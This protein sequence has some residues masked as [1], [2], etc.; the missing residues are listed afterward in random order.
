MTKLFKG[1][2][3]VMSVNKIETMEQSYGSLEEEYDKLLKSMKNK[4]FPEAIAELDYKL[5]PKHNHFMDIIVD[6]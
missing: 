2:H 4:V 6:N 3:L 1:N 5:P